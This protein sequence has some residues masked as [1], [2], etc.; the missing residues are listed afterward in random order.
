MSEELDP[1]VY[2]EQLKQKKKTTT[3]KFLTDFYT[4]IQAELGKAM[5][6]GQEFLVRRLA[7]ATSIV[8]KERELLQKG[9]D[10]YVLKDDIV[11]YIETVSKKAVKIIEL[12]RYP[13]AIPSEVVAKVQELKDMNVFDRFY[14]VYTD[15]TDEVS[16]QVAAESRRRDPI[17][18]GAFE[19]KLEGI[20][21]VFDRF[22]FIA[23]WEDEYCDLTL[24]KMV[25]AMS[26]KNK[27]ILHNT[28]S[29]KNPTEE[30]V[31]AY[32]NALNERDKNR[33]MLRPQKKSFFQKVKLA[34][35]ALVS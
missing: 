15:Y 29:I 14:I 33:F 16:K 25:A 34:F 2:F 7:F 4:V 27:D 35:K 3:D 26:E 1:Q 20:W 8:T 6:T 24:S 22:Y 18:F 17:L 32:I 23:D 28:E 10:V 9:I 21:D 12:E 30:E 31:R 13:R 19:Q 11:E 5:V